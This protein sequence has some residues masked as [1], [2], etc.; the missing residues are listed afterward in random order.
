MLISII[1]HPNSLASEVS[2]EPDFVS[3]LISFQKA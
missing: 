2:F 1:L 3:Y